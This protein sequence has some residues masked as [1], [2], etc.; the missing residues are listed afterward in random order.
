MSLGRRLSAFGVSASPKHAPSLIS[1][2]NNLPTFD[3]RSVY[4]AAGE[5][6]FTLRRECFSIFPIRAGKVFTTYN[7]LA[8]ADNTIFR[9]EVRPQAG[10]V[11]CSICTTR[12][13]PIVKEKHDA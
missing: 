10:E 1:A 7:P 8:P 3:G 4:A 13:I 5:P 6:Q 11:F 9:N 2:L 12:L